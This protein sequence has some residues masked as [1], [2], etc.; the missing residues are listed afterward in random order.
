MTNLKFGFNYG[1]L[2]NYWI[3]GGGQNSGGT[4]K[5]IKF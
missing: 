5:R 4:L 1:T 2:I 3:F